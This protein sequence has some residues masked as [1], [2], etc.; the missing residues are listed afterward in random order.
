MLVS[1]LKSKIHRAT[2]TE[3]KIEY[4]GSITIDAALIKAA[5]LIVGEKVLVVNLNNGAR[6]ET[7]VIEGGAGSGTIC[8]NGAAAHHFSVGELVI[9]MSFA[10]MTEEEAKVF[11]ST[12]IKVDSKNKTKG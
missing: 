6:V 8:V 9:I 2:V 4:E 3:S 12:V 11:T 10:Q 5:R 1:I 7:Y